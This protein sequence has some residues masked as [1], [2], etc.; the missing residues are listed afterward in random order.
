M[1]RGMYL[2]HGKHYVIVSYYFS[3]PNRF[4]TL[5]HTLKN[6]RNMCDA[7]FVLRKQAQFLWDG[8]HRYE[9]RFGSVSD[10]LLIAEG[11]SLHLSGNKVY[12]SSKVSHWSRLT[13]L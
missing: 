3:V 10:M 13:K 4:Q 9:V 12:P 7:D 6:T 5:C 8:I 1:L 2:A 11:N